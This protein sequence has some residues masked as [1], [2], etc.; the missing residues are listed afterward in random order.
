MLVVVAHDAGGAEVLSSYI[1]QQ[2]LDCLYVLEGPARAIFERKLGHISHVSLTDAMSQASS[3]LCGTSWQ[4]DLEFNAIQV[5]LSKGKPVIAFLD[6]WTNYQ[7]R[8]VRNHKICLPNAIWV[9]DS[10]AYE[11]AKKV[12]PTLPITM[13]D[14]PYFIEM[15]SELTALP[16]RKLSVDSPQS[17]LYVCE[18]IREH[19]LKQ[20]GDENYWGYTEEDA[21]RYFLSN[22]EALECSIEQ[23][24]LRPHPSETLEK[25][26]WV[27][28]TFDL[29]IKLGGCATLLEEITQNDIVVGCESMAMVIALFAEKRVISTIPPKGASCVLPH[30]EVMHLHKLIQSR[31]NR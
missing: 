8:F 7:E 19:A 28:D 30:V 4:S 27:L 16:K 11:I 20:H 15:K 3:V 25:Y 31:C 10:M 24:T 9:G 2:A 21:V 6:H 29:P 17:I 13:V 1:K 22:L 14:N 23:V 26:Q 18:P 5:A 12:F